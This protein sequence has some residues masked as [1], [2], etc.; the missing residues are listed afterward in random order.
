VRC[1]HTVEADVVAL[2]ARIEAQDGRLDVL[3][4]NAW[5][6]YEQQENAPEFFGPFWEQPMWRWEGCSSPAYGRASQ[7]R[8]GRVVADEAP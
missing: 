8:E 6:G 7:L 1:D 4:N 2:V 5:G 3:V